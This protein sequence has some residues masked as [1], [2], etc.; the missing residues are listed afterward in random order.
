MAHLLDLL[1]C[2]LSILFSSIF[3]LVMHIQYLYLSSF[4]FFAIRIVLVSGFLDLYLVR[5]PFTGSLWFE[6]GSLFSASVYNCVLHRLCSGGVWEAST[7]SSISCSV[8]STLP[9]SV[10][11]LLDDCFCHVTSVY[12]WCFTGWF[13]INLDLTCHSDLGI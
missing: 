13:L 10:I 5:N 9:S 1:A 4:S 6:S 8:I 12:V 2:A 7:W 3:I 11:H